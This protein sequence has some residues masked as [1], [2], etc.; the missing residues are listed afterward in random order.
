MAREVCYGCMKPQAMCLCGRVPLVENRTHV[1][2]L[3]HPR[4]RSHAIGTAR[5]ANLGLRN[6]RVEVAWNAGLREDEP[7]PWLPADTALLYPAPDARDLPTLAKG[8]RPRNLLVLDGTWHTAKTLYRQKRW[9]HRLPHVRFVPQAPSRYRLRREPAADYVSTIEAIVEALGVLEPETAGLP[10]LL[11]AFD[12]MIDDQLAYVQRG[13][14]GRHARRRRPQAQHRLPEALVSGVSRVVVVYAET[15]RARC[16]AARELVQ[17]TAHALGSDASFQC[18][19]CP[20]GGMPNATVLAHMQLSESDFAGAADLAGFRSAFGDFLAHGDQPPIV[21]AW[22]QSTFD[23]LRAAGVALPAQ[24]VLKSAYRGRC[25]AMHAS[26]DDVIKA[27][28]LSPQPGALHGRAAWRVACAVAV[29]RYLHGLQA[30]E[31][32]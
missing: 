10:A 19:L 7:P 20:G 18:H 31:L 32:V 5:L 28:S 23:L 25:G 30:R 4:E 3:Q 1:L 29:A 27:E 12:A 24:L 6:V 21:A 16:D 15:S 26:L 8:E 9:L 13:A 14:S 11:R 17:V 22:N 2:V